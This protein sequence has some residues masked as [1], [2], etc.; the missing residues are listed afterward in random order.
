[1][2]QPRLA[3]QTEYGRMY[4]RSTSEQAT[5]PSITTVISRAAHDLGGWYGYTAAQAA[6]RDDRLR[7]ALGSPA[8]LRAVVRDA[9]KAA[10]RH[11]DAAAARGDRVHSYAE[12]IAL[13][14]M[15]RP[16]RAA[17][18]RATL[19]EHGE[20]RFASRFDEWWDLYA[21]EPLAVEVTVWNSTV[22]YAG[23]LDLVAR[24]AG[25][26]CLIDYKTKGTDRDG[27]VKALDPK[28]VTQLVA[29]LKA[30]EQL[31]DAETGRWEPWAHGDADLLLGV[32]IGE[33]EVVPVQAVPAVLEAHWYK[34]CALHRVWTH[35]TALAAA[36][37]AL[38]PVPPPPVTAPAAD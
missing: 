18:A 12:Q 19:A 3:E 29:G 37:P 35:E 9:A 33:T 7:Q 34:F 1:M 28:V 26:T 13:R 14:A 23:T 16:H 30:E 11:R 5:V 21:P 25:R 31:V 24:I 4:A 38:R 20:E 17:E 32:A 36:G 8:Q 22:G 2:T 6:V 15:G 27:R 10:E